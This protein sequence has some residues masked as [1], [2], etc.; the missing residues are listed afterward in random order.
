MTEFETLHVLYASCNLSIHFLCPF[1]KKMGLFIL[2]FL[3]NLFSYSS[4]IYN[5][6]H[7]HFVFIKIPL[8]KVFII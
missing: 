5:F 1:F 2:I 7:F 8:A 6:L 4:Y 3:K